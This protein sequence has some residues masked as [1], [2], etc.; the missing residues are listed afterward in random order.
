MEKRM[1]YELGKNT[2]VILPC[3]RTGRDAVHDQNKLL[4]IKKWFSSMV[5]HDIFIICI[6]LES[7]L[8]QSVGV[9]N[10]ENFACFWTM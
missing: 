10:R 8:I 1:S 2:S 6:N 3:R 9:Q 5:L 7:T 4:S